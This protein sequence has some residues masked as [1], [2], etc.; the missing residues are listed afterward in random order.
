M[1]RQI[2]KPN[3]TF[4]LSTSDVLVAFPYHN[5]LVVGSNPEVAKLFQLIFVNSSLVITSA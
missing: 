3:N 4:I 1:S 5:G 2:S